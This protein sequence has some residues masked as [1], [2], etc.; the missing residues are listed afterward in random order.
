MPK[1]LFELLD[2][3]CS[4][5]GGRILLGAPVEGR[6]EAKRQVRCAECGAGAE[7]GAKARAPYEALCMCGVRLSTGADAGLRCR[8]VEAPTPERPQE[9]IVHHVPH[10]PGRRS[11]V[12]P[13]PVSAPGMND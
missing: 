2:H 12:G 9:V 6:G 4:V 5:C 13:R 1:P 8:K 3:A 11:S 7:V 10:G